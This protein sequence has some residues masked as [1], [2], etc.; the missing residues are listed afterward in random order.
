[1]RRDHPLETGGIPAATGVFGYF[2]VDLLTSSQNSQ[3][4]LAIR[5]GEPAGVH[6]ARLQPRSA[7]VERPPARGNIP[8]DYISRNSEPTTPTIAAP[9]HSLPQSRPPLHN[10]NPSTR[11]TPIPRPYGPRRPP[12]TAPTNTARNHHYTPHHRA[13]TAVLPRL[14]ATYLKTTA[15]V[16]TK[17]SPNHADDIATVVA[18]T[19]VG[20]ASVVVTPLAPASLS[21]II[22]TVAD[23][24]RQ[25]LA[26]TLEPVPH[27]F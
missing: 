20:A 22:A 17:R 4:G 7:R 2:T 9:M 14:P 25:M 13:T 8:V 16:A 18:A 12:P 6:T 15:A 5:T 11:P 23:R 3:L 19:A 10:Q 26:T 24:N 1:M 27:P 21:V